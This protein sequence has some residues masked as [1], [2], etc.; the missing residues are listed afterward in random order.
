VQRARK[1]LVSISAVALVLVMVAPPSAGSSASGGG[2]PSLWERLLGLFGL[3][4]DEQLASR[5]AGAAAQ[6]AA[7]AVQGPVAKATPAAKQASGPVR[8]VKE[9]G[10]GGPPTSGCLRSVMGGCRRSCRP[11]L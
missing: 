1:L 5:P 11:D 8:R 4:D 10:A 9:L 6:A 3:G 2:G 7:A